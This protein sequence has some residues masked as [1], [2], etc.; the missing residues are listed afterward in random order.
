MEQGKIGSL[1]HN[2][3][4]VV[5]VMRAFFGRFLEISGLLIN[6]LNH[7]WRPERCL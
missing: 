6:P 1:L 3:G 7:A 4:Y 2:C 5:L